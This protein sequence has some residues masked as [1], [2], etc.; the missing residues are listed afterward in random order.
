[1]N[2]STSV[3]LFG[4]FVATMAY[5]I[6]EHKRL[7]APVPSKPPPDMLDLPVS[8]SMQ[9]GDRVGPGATSNSGWYTTVP[10]AS[11]IPGQ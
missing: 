1:M 3:V 11:M 7:N 8:A 6:Y 2:L 4:M 9:P 10:N 5:L